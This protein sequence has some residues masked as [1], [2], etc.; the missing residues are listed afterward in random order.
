MQDIEK[1]LKQ[2]KEGQLGVEEAVKVIKD[3]GYEDIGIAKIDYNRSKRRGFPE[4]VLCEGKTTEQVVKILSVHA[5]N[6]DNILATR[7]TEEVYDAVKGVLPEARYNTLARTITIEKKPLPRE[8]S[9]IVVCAGTSD[10]PVAEEVYETASIMG[11]KVGKLVDVGVAGIHRLLNNL[12][13]LRKAR[14]IVVCAGMEG[15]LPSVVT[16]LV[17]KPIIGVPTSVG[18]GAS[19]NGLSPLLTMLNSC[20]AGLGVVNIDNGFGAAYLANSINKLK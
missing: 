9:I 15:A 8:G 2:V 7:A 19:F 1:I 11:N 6:N 4:V 20:A 10:L 18:Y 14:V 16:G 13:E 12:E 17:D 3:P 5:K